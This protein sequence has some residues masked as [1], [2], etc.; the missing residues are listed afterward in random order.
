MRFAMNDLKFALRM[1]RKNPGFT[2]V[3]VLTLA[4]GIGATT[5]VFSVVDGVLLQPLE[6]PGSERIVH[7]W[8][9]DPEQGFR[10]NNTSPANFVDWRRDNTV[11]EAI[12]FTAEFAGQETR[13]FVYNEG[14]ESHRLNGRMVATN[15]FAVFGLKPVLGR[16]FLPEEEVR[17]APRVVVISHQLWH[18]LY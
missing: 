12:A 8:E 2:A 16:S 4:L 17:G 18:Q 10:R 7:V 14:G 13:S 6:Y 3:A 15:Y 11:F 1:L 9:S 5:T